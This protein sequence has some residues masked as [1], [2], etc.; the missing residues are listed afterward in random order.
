MVADIRSGG[1]QGAVGI[2]GA[3]NRHG[4]IAV[5]VVE[6][7]RHALELAEAVGIDVSA[8]GNGGSK[9]VGMTGDRVE[10]ADPAHRHPIDIDPVRIDVGTLQEQMDEFH[11]LLHDLALRVILGE[12]VRVRA[13]VEGPGM[14]GRA[15]RHDDKAG[16]IL[17]VARVQEHL[18]AENG[19]FVVIAAFT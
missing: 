14:V 16:I 3:G 19:P 8:D 5:A 15:L 13:Y 9:D 7:E 18:G 10:S 12:I 6:A 17:P 4:R 1:L 11:H 2:P